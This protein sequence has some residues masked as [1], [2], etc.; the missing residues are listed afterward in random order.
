[1]ED[2]LETLSEDLMNAAADDHSMVFETLSV[3]K[4]GPVLFVDIAA[5]P[6]NLLA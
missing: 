1:M 3:R 5:P 6:M 2:G 4:D